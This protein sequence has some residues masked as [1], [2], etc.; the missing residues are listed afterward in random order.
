MDANSSLNVLPETDFG[1]SASGR[2]DFTV[3]F[4][5]VV[6]S[7]VP[8]ALF[9]ILVP[10][11]LLWLK[12]EPRKTVENSRLLIKL[13]LITLY[14][15][16]QLV[17]LT[18][19]TVGPLPTSKPQIAA[20]ALVFVNG[21]LLALLSYV[22]HTRSVRPSTIIN[23]Y[24]L[25]TALFDCAI[26]R[27]LWLLDGAHAVA[28]LF[29]AA[30]SAKA[31]ILIS[32]AW[33]KRSILR[34]Q[35][36]DLSPETTSG[37]LG[38]S[39]FWWINP[40]MKLGFSSLLTE[41]D[42]YAIENSLLGKRLF[43]QAEKSWCAAKKIKSNALFWSTIW[44]SRRVFLLGISSRICLMAFKYAQ[45]F[46][47]QRTIG[48]ASN[49]DEDKAIGWGLTGAWCCVFIGLAIANAFYWHMTYQF[50]TAVRGSLISLVYNKTL[51]LSITA[52]DESIAVTL[53]SADTENICLNFA[54]IHEMWASPIECA[55]ALYL[56][57]RQLGMAFLAPMV[58]AI[59]STT[60]ILMI[61]KY[62]A[63]AQKRWVRG[64]QTRIDVTASMLGSMKEVKM[65]G[66]T[67][68]LNNMVQSLRVRELDLS[69]KF[70]KL[71]CWRVFFQNTMEAIAPLATFATY[72]VISQETGNPLSTASAYTSLSLIYLLSNPMSTLIRTIPGM[73]ASLACFDRMQGF[74]LSDSCKDHR[75][76]LSV[77]DS[78]GQQNTQSFGPNAVTQGRASIELLDRSNESSV[79]AGQPLMIVSETSFGWS[80]A[81]AP[82]LRNISFPIRKS[83]FT[84]VIGSVG[85]GKSTLMKA[86]LGELQPYKGFVYTDARRIAFVDQKPWIQNLTIRQNILGISTYHKDWYDRVVHA[87]GLEQDIGEMPDKDAT[88]AGSGGVSL[89]GGQNQRLALARA[90]YS[91]AG[92]LIL[93]D[94]FS[95]QDSSTE[96]HIYRM[97]F[98]EAGLLRELG[99][100]VVCV[101]NA[102]HRLAYADH[103]VAL[104]EHG[105]V[106]HQGTFEQLKND[107]DYF[108]G[109]HLRQNGAAKGDGDS[110]K[111]NDKSTS[112]P[113]GPE[114]ET[115]S[116]NR[117]LGELAT[118]GYYFNTVPKW[119]VL[120]FWTGHSVITQQSV[121]NFYLGLYAMLAGL[122]I[123]GI[124][125]AAVHYLVIMVPLSSEV[126]H[127]RLLR[128]VMNAPLSFFSRM[129][130]GVT[131]NRFSRDMSVI[132]T[133]L[134]FALIDL[135]IDTS[136]TIMSVILMCVFSGYF[137]ATLPPLAFFCWLLQR[138]YLRTSRQIRILELQAN[139]PLFTQF[140]DTLQGLSS[141]RSFGWVKEFEEQHFQFLDASQ[142]PYYLLFSI[143][144]WLAVVLDLAVAALATI[145]MV[146][147]VKLRDNFEPKFVAMALLNV[148]SFSQYLTQLIKNY[149]QLETSLGAV[150]RTKEF[151]TTT[152][153][154]NLPD[155]VVTPPESWPPYGHVQIDRLTAAYTASGE[156][157]LHDVSLD[158][159]AGFK[160]GVVGRSG[161]G[162]SSLMACLL[163]MLEVDSNSS[164]KFDGIDITTL[165]RQTVRASVAVVPQHPFFMKKTTLRDNLVPRGEQAEERILAVLHRLR[166]KQAVEKLG[167]LDSILD[168]ERLSQGQRQLLCL[169]RAILANKKIIFLDEAS[170]N[171]DAKSE[172]LIRQVVQEEFVGRTVIAI[173]H[174]LGA[175][176]DFD[177]V[178]VMGGGRVIEWDNPREL[179]KRESEFKRLWDL[180]SG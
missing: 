45:P 113:Q 143:Q 85:S 159:A 139:S 1:P 42:L 121:N 55:V 26:S 77:R 72:V 173:A 171:V 106:Q 70:R 160:V 24:L 69:K 57:Y 48:F 120:F 115:E 8:S 67:D 52:F 60:G 167:G 4:E 129:D 30:T 179:L 161:S 12:R 98:P 3:L 152:D 49:L 16:L 174:R 118:Y 10:Q 116:A 58:V 124:M 27:T 80:K 33:E 82:V 109:L 65:L 74:L 64:I 11:R 162:K 2:F 20:A 131:T 43:A 19:W 127:A 59:V 97:L 123:I 87:C 22:E 114:E 164:I 91:M 25:F 84:F 95:G 53:M 13:G 29:T 54:S 73:K 39:V 105:T 166:M 61:A 158:I 147:I 35:Y 165:P 140:L 51:D 134:P 125:G 47:I 117:A 32:E 63:N 100:T 93:D 156:P 133:E 136:V 138:F 21:L 89:S 66:L 7:I 175:V 5:N 86:L 76:P 62:I 137:V 14:T 15:G 144:R 102:I 130:V 81:E 44:S 163:R 36:R 169:A 75:L 119:H 79:A 78:P 112:A 40:L 18:Y 94:V 155:E 96:E 50:V 151:C 142:R 146:L 28:R 172:Q 177:R 90:I 141:V 150:S 126:L 170:S 31:L 132:D 56:L 153:S 41:R 103:V 92:V 104:G 101:T 128:T 34:V 68:V 178:A 83:H 9:L 180:S 149:T 6:L 99:T 110:S 17:V 108:S 176:V 88:K 145:L 111:A 168:I 157:V 46:L 71:M 37:I 38:R 154:E 107:T 148:T 23:V 122:A 135:A